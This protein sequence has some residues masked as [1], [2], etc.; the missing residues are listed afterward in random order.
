VLSPVTAIQIGKATAWRQKLRPGNVHS[1]DDWEE[2]LL[3]E[4]ER[5]EIW[6]SKMEVPNYCYTE[7]IL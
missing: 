4:I 5:L 1:A 7:P 6:Q 2:L 3:P